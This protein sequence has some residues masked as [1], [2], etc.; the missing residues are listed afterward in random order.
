MYEKAIF[1]TRKRKVSHQNMIFF[2]ELD[3]NNHKYQQNG[4]V[5]EENHKG[6][7]LFIIRESVSFGKNHQ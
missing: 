6:K 7:F 5:I 3:F 1:T 4:T 2:N